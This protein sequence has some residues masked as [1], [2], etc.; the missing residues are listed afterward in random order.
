ML[1]QIILFY[2]LTTDIHIFG[3]VGWVYANVFVTIDETFCLNPILFFQEILKLL[4]SG[5]NL[6]FF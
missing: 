3:Y 2:S 4:E 5:P 1:K 6:F